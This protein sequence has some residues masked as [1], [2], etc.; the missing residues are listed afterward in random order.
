MVAGH[1]FVAPLAVAMLAGVITQAA[2]AADA[3]AGRA[4]AE[5]WCASC[6]V[7]GEA[8]Q[9]SASDAAPTF[10]S[11]ANRPDATAD[12]LRAFLSEPHA[13][14]MKGIV[15]PRLEIDDLVA[16]IMSLRVN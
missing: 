10:A 9:S 14:A 3:Q 7:I 2:H 15:L 5:S 12:G 13:D 16:Y 6:H 11:I 1:F 4:L 8:G